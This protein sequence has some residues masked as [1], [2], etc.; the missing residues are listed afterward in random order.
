[1]RYKNILKMFF[2]IVER[3]SDKTA[4]LYKKSG[5]Y[6]G[7][8]YNEF[9]EK[10]VN[11]A[12]GLISAGIAKGDRVAMLS[13][14]RPE[15]AISDLGIIHSGALTVPIYTSISSKQI[16]YLLNA[17]GAEFIVISN[18]KQ[19][20]KIQKIYQNLNSLKLVIIL[21]ESEEK[22]DLK[23]KTF[24]DIIDSG[25][26][27]FTENKKRLDELSEQTDSD[28]TFTIIYTSGTTGISKGVML[29][30]R[31]ILSNAE[32]ALK[33]L[34]ITD[35]DTFLSFLPLSHVLERMAGQ[36]I[37]IYKGS[38]IA[39][40]ESL[41]TLKENM[42]E[43]K[44]TVIITVPR[45]FEKMYEVIKHNI[46][47]KSSLIK[48]VLLWCLYSGVEYEKEKQKGKI[49]LYT[50][51]RRLIGDKLIYKKLRGLTGGRLRFYI[52]GGAHLN[53]DIGEFF[54]TTGIKIIEGYGLTETSPVI[55]VNRLD[56]YRFG[57]V[58]KP[59]PG[60]D[61]KISK[62]GEIL[63]RGPNVM[64]GYYNDE[65][66]TKLAIDDEGWFHT[67]DL[68]FLDKDGFLTI[69]DRKKNIIVISSGKNIA[70]QLIEEL[71]LTSKYIN[72]AV[73]IGHKK[74]FMSALIV[75]HFQNIKIYAELKKILYKSIDELIEHNE[76]YHL[77]KKEIENVSSN[78]SDFER[79]KKFTLLKSE[80]DI[81]SEE[82][83]PTFKIKRNVI[84]KK[85]AEIIN[86][87]YI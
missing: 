58:G 36:F 57:T 73:V 35:K 33:A 51:I 45:I 69:T 47:K 60:I 46:E 32:A 27:N 56:E 30:H 24:N 26:K 25:K 11:F 74:K 12:S 75:P 22:Y 65:Q 66:S 78:L 9:I 16:E 50:K 48:S 31:N 29:T 20:E 61:V 71:V 83:T 84:E 1:M 42:V 2:D 85:Y 13:E 15:W 34:P 10:A 70:P 44:P 3:N 82:I 54:D 14:N 6:V 8:N 37:P 23:V 17:S 4:L 19:L 62:E 81:E 64:K 80:F 87:M 18:L 38:S 39:Y 28:D 76:I 49:L 72:Q 52:C 55:T 86:K 59:L 40:A 63:T 77:I 68:G 41:S 7:I 43:V 5:R 53:K 67:G 21:F 79:I